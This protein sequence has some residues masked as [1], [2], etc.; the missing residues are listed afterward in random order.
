MARIMLA[1]HDKIITSPYPVCQQPP[2]GL[3]KRGGTIS[4]LPL[5]QMTVLQK[6]D[7]VQLLGIR[8]CQTNKNTRLAALHDARRSC[9]TGFHTM[10]HVNR[11][12]CRT[13]QTIP[14]SRKQ[15]TFHRVIECG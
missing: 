2:T 10:F 13:N 12:P 14:N 5:P 9:D 7:V 8:S 6:S 15:S 4:T 1:A 11:E 3:T